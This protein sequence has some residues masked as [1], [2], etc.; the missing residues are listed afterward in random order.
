MQNRPVIDLKVESESECTNFEVLNSSSWNLVI[1]YPTWCCCEVS[2]NTRLEEYS[3]GGLSV[4]NTVLVHSMRSRERTN[5]LLQE[6]NRANDFGLKYS[7]RRTDGLDRVNYSVRWLVG[8]DLLWRFLRGISASQN[9][10]WMGNSSLI[11]VMCLRYKA[12]VA[13]PFQYSVTYKL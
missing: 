7:G 4:C 1:I 9:K 5:L 11:N 2:C 10:T 6:S 8:M 13:C 3:R 12:G